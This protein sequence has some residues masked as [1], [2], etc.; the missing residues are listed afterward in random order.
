MRGPQRPSIRPT[1]L[2]RAYAVATTFFMPIAAFFVVRKLRRAGVP[3]HRAHEVVGNATEHRPGGTLIWFHAASVGE[4]L[5]VLS[6]I[7][8]MGRALPDARFLITS[9]TATSAHL[10]AARMPARTQHQFAPLDGAGPLRRFL[11]TWRPDAAI[12]V[13][14][15]LWPNMLIHTRRADIPMAMV[16]ARLSDKSLKSWAKQ[17][18]TAAFL[19]HHFKLVLTQTTAMAQHLIDLGTP[20]DKTAKGV[21]LKSLS[22]PLPVHGKSLGQMRTTLGHR[23]VW[24]ACSTHDGEETDVL[25]A[26]AKLLKTHPDLCLILVPRHPER[27][28]DVQKLI[29]NAGFSFT[30]RSVGG[31]PEKQ[32][33]LADTLGEMGLWYSLAPFV[34]LGGSLHPIGGHNPF[35]P[36]HFGAAVLS[37]VHI[38]NFAD[39][40]SA[41]E[42]KGGARLVNYATQIAEIADTWLRHPEALQTARA[43][44]KAFVA[45]QSGTLDD[46]A[47]QLITAL[48]IA[49]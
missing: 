21:D 5:S 46:V 45:D 38:T 42:A 32:V 47:N 24:A 31:L 30:T 40:Y 23:P 4:S 2:F 37:G 22:A 33:Y 20:A 17:H 19:L 25:E 8:A 43:G 6:L 39:A 18:K 49:P 9:G 15:E 41:L 7:T 29:E 11:K 28:P 10:I 16:N 1:A 44:A 26:H 13:E 3:S 35:E 36:A 34:F 27:S 48:D 14:S 12:L